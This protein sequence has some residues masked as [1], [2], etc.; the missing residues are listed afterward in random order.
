[1]AHHVSQRGASFSKG[2]HATSGAARLSNSFM[3][4]EIFLQYWLG[5]K[6]TI[7]I[8]V[9]SKSR[10]PTVKSRDCDKYKHFHLKQINTRHRWRNWRVNYLL[11]YLIWWWRRTWFWNLHHFNVLV[12]K[13]HLHCNYCEDDVWNFKSFFWILL[14][15]LQSVKL[16]AWSA[17]VNKW[18]T[19]N[20]HI[21]MSHEQHQYCVCLKPVT[22]LQ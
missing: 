9:S 3:T 22:H 15:K 4:A 16:L 14:L 2:R 18:L 8:V 20:L 19:H 5:S 17:V 11:L 6:K 21:C 12:C 7:K 10:F 1:M 13:W